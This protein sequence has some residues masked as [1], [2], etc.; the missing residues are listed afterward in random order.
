M[1]FTVTPEEGFSTEALET[2]DPFVS[3][4][5]YNDF[6]DINVTFLLRKNNLKALFSAF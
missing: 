5:F 2:L 6:V 4:F 1:L 3:I